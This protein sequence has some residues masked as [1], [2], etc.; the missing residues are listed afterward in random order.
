MQRNWGLNSLREILGSQEAKPTTKETPEP[1]GL[2]DWK[3][4]NEDAKDLFWEFIA[5]N[6][7]S[8]YYD[9]QRLFKN[10]DGIDRFFDVLGEMGYTWAVK[11]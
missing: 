2:D 9:L 5:L 11:K 4:N 6:R 1:R 8:R 3:L 7:T 10:P